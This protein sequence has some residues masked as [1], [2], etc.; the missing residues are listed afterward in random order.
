MQFFG[1]SETDARVESAAK[2]AV[3]LNIFMYVIREME[4]AINDCNENNQNDN[5]DSVHAV[6]SHF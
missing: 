6:R 4:D 3:Y 2:G 5:D 1:I